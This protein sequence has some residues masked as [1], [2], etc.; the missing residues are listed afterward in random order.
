M[1]GICLL[2]LIVRSFADP[3]IPGVDAKHPALKRIEVVT[4]NF[5]T[6][7]GT[8][9]VEVLFHPGKGSEEKAL[10]YAAHFSWA[11]GKVNAKGTEP[12]CSITKKD[13][14]AFVVTVR[15]EETKIYPMSYVKAVGPLSYEG[16]TMVFPVTLNQ[17]R[18]R[19]HSGIA[20]GVK[21]WYVYAEVKF[22]EEWI[23]YHVKKP[24]EFSLEKG[25]ELS[26]KQSH[27]FE[28]RS[29]RNLP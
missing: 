24:L 12:S 21:I 19:E 15:Y 5:S 25:I 17:E 2:V 16:S 23:A 20:T 26:S 7:S 27:A 9:T 28:F 1:N 3:P 18:K 4:E 29:P 22:E 8:D 10:Q 13:E 14:N 6:E 11:R